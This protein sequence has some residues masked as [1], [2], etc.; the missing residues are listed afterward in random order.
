MPVPIFSAVGLRHSLAIVQ[1]SVDVPDQ[2]RV[3]ANYWLPVAVGLEAP[4]WEAE[5]LER[6]A[7]P[8]TFPEASDWNEST[9]FAVVTKPPPLL[10]AI[11]KVPPVLEML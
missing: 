8:L 3:G 1:V 6:V 11:V 10:G 5:T 2:V 4:E 9:P 7:A